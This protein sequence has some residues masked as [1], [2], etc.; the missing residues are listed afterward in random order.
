[1]QLNEIIFSLQ[2]D[3][4]MSKVNLYKDTLNQRIRL[5][6]YKR[7]ATK[8]ITLVSRAHYTILEANKYRTEFKI[9]RLYCME[10][11]LRPIGQPKYLIGI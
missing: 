5:V 4:I 2:I 8:I 6:Q 7:E 11:I 10:Q 1:M 9:E 3:H